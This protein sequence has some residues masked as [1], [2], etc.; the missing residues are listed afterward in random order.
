MLNKKENPSIIDNLSNNNLHQ[1]KKRNSDLSAASPNK[2][3]EDKTSLRS[4]HNDGKL[5]IDGFRIEHADKEPELVDG[6][7]EVRV[8]SKIVLRIFGSG[9]T[10]FTF[11][12]FTSDPGDY[13]ETCSLT[14]PAKFKVIW[15][16][17]ISI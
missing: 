11:I 2:I 3:E 15:F 8:G 1:V 16:D 10:K 7:P 17:S 4:N 5:T 9:I 12:T 13:G 6:V 14:I